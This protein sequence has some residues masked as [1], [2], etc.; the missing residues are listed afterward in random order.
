MCFAYDESWKLVATYR[1]N[2]ASPKEMFANHNAGLDGSGGSSYIDNVILRDRD[3]NTSWVS[4]SDGTLEERR[5]YCQNWRADVLVIV[6]SN[7]TIGIIQ[8][9]RSYTRSFRRSEIIGY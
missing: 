1:E 3:A 7:I 8:R 4:A 2:D 9:D 5:Y 6:S